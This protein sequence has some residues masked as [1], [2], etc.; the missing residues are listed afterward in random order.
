MASYST[1]NHMQIPVTLVWPTKKPEPSRVE[2]GLTRKN[3]KNVSGM[4]LYKIKE[5]RDYSEKIDEN[6]TVV[7]EFALDT[8]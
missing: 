5:R 4:S 3:L 7:D 8:E 2:L 6:G 1:A